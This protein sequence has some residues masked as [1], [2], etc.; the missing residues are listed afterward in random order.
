MQVNTGKRRRISKLSLK[1]RPPPPPPSPGPNQVVVLDSP[2]ATQVHTS[3]PSPPPGE[4]PNRLVVV[5]S[6][7]GTQVHSPPPKKSPNQVGDSPAATQVHTSQPSPP[8]EKSPNQLVVVDSPAATQ[9][10][11]SQPSPPS[12]EFRNQFIVARSPAATQARISPPKTSP[13][14]ELGDGPMDGLFWR[15][16]YCGQLVPQSY[17]TFDSKILEKRIRHYKKCAAGIVPPQNAAVESE[18]TGLSENERLSVAMLLPNNGTSPRELQASDLGAKGNKQ[19]VQRNAFLLLMNN[20]NNKSRVPDAGLNENGSKQPVQRNAF[21]LLMNNRSNKS[22]VPVASKPN[23]KKKRP[24]SRRLASSRNPSSIPHYKLIKVG[25]NSKRLQPIVVDGFQYSSLTLSRIYFLSHFHSDHYIG[26]RKT[27]SDGTIYCTQVTANLLLRQFKI[28]PVHVRALPLNKPIKLD[29]QP[30][31]VVSSEGAASKPVQVVVTLI[32]ANHCPGSCIMLFQIGNKS[33]YR[34]HLHTGDF[35]YIKSM[36]AHKALKDINHFECIYLDTTYCNPKY[37]FP[38]QIKSIES[39]LKALERNGAGSK[40]VRRDT[41]FLFGSYSIGKEKI[42]MACAEKF[43]VKV[44]VSAAK[45]S[46]IKCFNWPREKMRAITRDVGETS[47]HVVPM[48]VLSF[49]RIGGYLSSLKRKYRRVIAIRPTG[50][51]YGGG[52]RNSYEGISSVH[53]TRVNG[54]IE[55]TVFGVAYSE[56]SSFSELQQCVQ[57]FPAFIIKPTVNAYT[58]SAEEQMLQLLGY[59]G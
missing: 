35:R 23:R 26:L 44:Y 1:Y 37:D 6:A 48:G 46:L 39:S 34:F 14:K 17:T 4:Y 53:T 56:H 40:V 49:K 28:N 45:F 32:D 59:R 52:S 8:P 16:E 29:M 24:W 57:D 55:V 15:C 20:R 7:A 43:N 10:H 3:Q 30:N 51:S 2:A 22:L 21:S 11:T 13:K 31:V 41:L 58:R 19:P 9:V 18:D 25:G 50:W 38:P 27:F 12:G 47:F 42:F 33:P 5:G 36:R 54:S